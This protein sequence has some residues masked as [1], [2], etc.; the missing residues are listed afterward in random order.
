[1]VVCRE[2]AFPLAQVLLDNTNRYY[3]RPPC[4]K[5]N[6]NSSLSIICP[7]L[8]YGIRGNPARAAVVFPSFCTTGTHCVCKEAKYIQIVVTARRLSGEAHGASACQGGYYASL[9]L[10]L[11]ISNSATETTDFIIAV[12][13]NSTKH[14]ITAAARVR[15]EF[16]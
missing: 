16:I 1:M 9:S 7:S 8:C 4:P 14:D 12:G 11:S 6:E 13:I 2:S 10:F 5:S 3:L 15:S